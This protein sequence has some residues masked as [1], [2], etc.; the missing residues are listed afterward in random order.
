MRISVTP[1]HVFIA[2]NFIIVP[3]LVLSLIDAPNQWFIP[4]IMFGFLVVGW[5][6][7]LQKKKLY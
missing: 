3:V 7:V 6:D 4:L 5:Y 2:S 1:R